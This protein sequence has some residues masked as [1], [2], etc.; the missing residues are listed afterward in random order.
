M[1]EIVEK[2]LSNLENYYYE[3]VEVKKDKSGRPKTYN[4]GSV[5]KR[6]IHPSTGELKIIQRRIKKEILAPI[7]LPIEVHGGVQKKSNITNAKP[8]K[9]HKYFFTTDLKNFYPSINHKQVYSTFLSL[10]FSNHLSSWLTRLTTWKYKLPQGTPTST[11]L[12]NLVFL[13]TDYKLIELCRNN[14]ITYTRYVDDLTFS[15]AQNFKD[16][17]DPI[18]QTVMGGGFNI[19]YRKTDYGKNPLVTGIEVSLNKIDA[20][21]H[22]KEKAINEYLQESNLKP[23]NNYLKNIR[24]VNNK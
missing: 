1:P 3:K 11:H 17:L 22:I 10:G 15:S 24:E 14:N 20:P 21:E 23:Y 19:S 18:L 7:P 2:V 13:P 4:D 8:H 9:G 16:I 5:K 6:I 12:S